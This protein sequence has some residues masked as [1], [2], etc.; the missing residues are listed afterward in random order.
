MP[1]EPSLCLDSSVYGWAS[2]RASDVKALEA[3]ALLEWHARG[4]V[5]LASSS[6]VEAEILHFENRALRKRVLAVVPAKDEFYRHVEWS[7][8]LRSVTERLSR[9][10]GIAADDMLHVVLAHQA[11]AD[12]LVTANTAQFLGEA[13]VA[14]E[15]PRW[16][17]EFG[18]LRVISLLNWKQ[19]VFGD[20]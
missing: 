14:M 4:L 5:R 13:E 7:R 10:L 8:G 17:L 12:F 6:W 18:D 9:E 19:E 20:H 3:R 11:R 2:S 15:S 1:G 16:S